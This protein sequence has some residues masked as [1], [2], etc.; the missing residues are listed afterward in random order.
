MSL[1]ACS[2]SAGDDADFDAGSEGSS[3]S[4]SN[5][6]TSAAS[7]TTEGS[8][9]STTEAT[10]GATSTTDDSSSFIYDVGAMGTTGEETPL[11]P[12][13]CFPSDPDCECNVDP[14]AP[15]DNGTNDPFTAMGLNCPGEPSVMTT[16][17]AASVAYGVRTG[18]GGDNT[19]DPREGTA[20]A[21][22]STG[23]IS[24][25]DDETPQ[26]GPQSLS[27]TYCNTDVGPGNDLGTL[28][29]SP[30]V[31]SDVGGMG[32]VDDPTL[33]GTGDCSNSL[34]GQ[35]EQGMSAEDYAEFRIE[36]TVPSDVGAFRFDFA[37][38][39]VEWPGYDGKE[40]NDLF[41]GWLESEQWT[42]NVSFDQMGNP[43]S[44]NASF[45]A[46]KDNGGSLPAFQG[47]CMRRHGGSGWLRTSAQVTPGEDI[48]IV[49][50][51]F[52]MSDSI[53]DS[54]VFIDNWE[55]GCASEEDGGPVTEPA[56]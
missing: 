38:F 26:G 34:Q 24:E 2:K 53:L 56:G 14:H 33:I 37:Y 15:C 44:L 49:L 1:L 42:G 17:D 23:D 13:G 36:T 12:A 27:P 31:P 22:L 40:F 3:N 51:I 35:F 18:F 25:L 28:L 21:V 47:T 29:P 4:D 50:A 41:V 20:Y 43:I 32:C 16:I 19:F 30:L 45:F 6:S 54:F 11:P 39:S 46:L 5:G 52:D 55:W 9:T 7:T 10:T 8:T 48:T